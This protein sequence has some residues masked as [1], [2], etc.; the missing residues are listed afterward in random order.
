MKA[1]LEF[2]LPE[3]QEEYDLAVKAQ[4]MRRSL[5]EI[6]DYLRDKA[7]Y[8]TE[9]EAKWQAYDEVY[10]QFFIILNDNNIKL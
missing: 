1:I 6:K 7:K 10:Q 2:L 3:D 5:I 8:E 4:D 9:D